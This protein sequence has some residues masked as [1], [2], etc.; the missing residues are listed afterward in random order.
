MINNAGIGPAAAD[1]YELR[2]QVNYLAPVLLTESLLPTLEAAQ[3]RVVNV[4]SAAQEKVDLTDLMSEKRF[5]GM[6]A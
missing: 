5:S 1:G 2:F 3:G 6:R 4:V